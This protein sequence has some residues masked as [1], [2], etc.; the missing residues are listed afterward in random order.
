MLTGR[1]PSFLHNGREKGSKFH[2]Y[3]GGYRYGL[4]LTTTVKHL[5]RCSIYIHVCYCWRGRFAMKT[6]RTDPS[7]EGEFN[8]SI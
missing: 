1:I 8:A 7:W 5:N 2:P 6:S 3:F 4:S